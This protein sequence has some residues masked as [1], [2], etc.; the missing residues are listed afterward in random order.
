[1]AYAPFKV[2]ITT[3]AGALFDGDATELLVPG[4]SGN[5]T[6]LA[7]HEPLITL[8]KKGVLRVVSE[9]GTTQTFPIEKGVLEVG[10]NKAIVLV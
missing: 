5:M 9:D 1:M 4:E 8:L 3:V 10:H 6:V 2:T 7:N